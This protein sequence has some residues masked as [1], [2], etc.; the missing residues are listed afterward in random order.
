MANGWYREN[1]QT[2][3]TA[4]QIQ[5]RIREMGSEIARDYRD[6]SLVLLC[7]LKGSFMFAADLCRAIDLPLRVEFLGVQS[8]GD[9]TVSSG[10]VVV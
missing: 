5:N 7:V 8:Y 4:E 9:D 10:V 1:L 2:L 3:Y 6:K